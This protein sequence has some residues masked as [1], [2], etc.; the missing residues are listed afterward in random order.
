MTPSWYHCVPLKMQAQSSSNGNFKAKR[1]SRISTVL[2]GESPV[3]GPNPTQVIDKT[4]AGCVGNSIQYT[5][6]SG[7]RN[8]P[9]PRDTLEQ[10]Q[11][12]AATENIGEQQPQPGSAGGTQEGRQCGHSSGLLPRKRRVEAPEVPS[13]QVNST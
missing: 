4:C 7:G 1:A 13:L 12:F 8:C 6:K 3:L 11:N 2:Q 9:F 5:P 10:P